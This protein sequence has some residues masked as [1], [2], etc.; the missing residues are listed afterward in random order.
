V[1]SEVV[2]LA[3]VA[4]TAAFGAML[5]ATMRRNRRLTMAWGAAWVLCLVVVGASVA[6][7]LNEGF[8][9]GGAPTD[10][11]MQQ[12]VDELDTAYPDQIEAIDFENALPLDP[13]ALFIDT[14]SAM[15]IDEERAFVCGQ[16]RPR[17][18]A[19]DERIEI[20]AITC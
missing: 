3:V 8:W 19:V 20:Y 4:G 18:D 17:V 16:V 10:A 5:I 7:F 6:S 12:L 1:P 9:F 2:A 11:E 14:N 15:T 13:P